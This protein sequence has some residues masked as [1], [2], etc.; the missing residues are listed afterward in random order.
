MHRSRKDA[1]EPAVEVVQVAGCIKVDLDTPTP[2]LREFIRRFCGGW[3]NEH[4]KV[5]SSEACQHIVSRNHGA[6]DRMLPCVICQ[7]SMVCHSGPYECMSY[8][9]CARIVRNEVNERTWHSFG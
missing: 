3:L 4:A 8:S 6:R 7:L 1:S 5:K 2:V 9:R